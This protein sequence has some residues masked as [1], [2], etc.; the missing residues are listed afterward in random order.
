M[1]R[2]PEGDA[3]GG[4]H[5]RRRIELIEGFMAISSDRM[6]MVSIYAVGHMAVDLAC[7]SLMFRCVVGAGGM[8]YGAFA[9]SAVP[10]A[11]ASIAG[12]GNALFHLGGGL[13]VLNVSE[14]RLWALG[15]FVS[16][17]A[18]GIYYGTML[19]RGDVAAFAA[20]PAVM[21]AVAAFLALPYRLMA[22]PFPR[23]APVSL[24][25][26]GSRG[27]MA[28]ALC[29]FMVVAVRSYVGLAAEFPWKG[30]GLWGLALLG[31]AVLGKAAGGLA[32][33]RYGA[34]RSSV[35]FLIVAAALLPLSGSAPAGVASM[36]A[37]N[38][39]MPITLWAMARLMPGAKGFA[40]GTLTFAIFLGYLPAQLRVTPPANLDWTLA[41]ITLAS[42]AALAYG[43]R[44]AM[45]KAAR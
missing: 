41:A 12:L 17:G 35:P 8:S 14:E 22:N 18:I 16:P 19:G 43:L 15:V 3:Y 1:R 2:P 31:A 38:M 26:M 5:G 13:D 44:H 10:V 24:G 25:G 42:A 4:D 34:F 6:L 21:L 29:L 37:L 39:T 32:A 9:F 20:F 23:N 40:F 30:L 33:D 7:A 27:A 36:L 45:R 11:A 28:A